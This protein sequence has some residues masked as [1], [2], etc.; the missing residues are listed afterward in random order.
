MYT[1][2]DQLL[3]SS[4]N[5]CR[6]L[7]F[8]KQS[9]VSFHQRNDKRSREKT[10]V[11][12]DNISGVISYER[13]SSGQLYLANDLRH[14]LH[15][16]I[17]TTDVLTYRR[18]NYSILKDTTFLHVPCTHNFVSRDKT[19]CVINANAKY[20]CEDNVYVKDTKKHKVIRKS[21]LLITEMFKNGLASNFTF[22]EKKRASTLHTTPSSNVPSSSYKETRH[23]SS[24]SSI[25]TTS[26]SGSTMST[27]AK[28]N[29][30]KRAKKKLQ[31]SMKKPRSRV[32]HS[33]ILPTISLGWTSTNCHEY[34]K[35]KA[36]TAG[37]IKPFLRDGG[38]SKR[39]KQLLLNCVCNVLESLPVEQC[40]NVD[41]ESNQFVTQMRK[42][43]IGRFQNLLGGSK[44]YNGR[45]RVEGITI[46]VPSAIGFH[47]DTMNCGRKGMKSVVSINVNVPINDET[48]PPKTPLSQWLKDNGCT[49]SFPVSIILYSRKVVYNFAK[50]LS[51]SKAL[52]KEDKLSDLTDWLLTECVGS[53]ID[54]HSTVWG[55]ENF[56]DEFM[57]SAEVKSSSRFNGRM[58]TTTETIDK[59]VSE[60]NTFCYDS[61]HQYIIS[62]YESS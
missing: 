4:T 41:L 1:E 55:N 34:S 59:T 32:C 57:A 30:R 24:I 17:P 44:E 20:T 8:T 31:Q 10:F 15:G 48:V 21:E 12:V 46:T 52:G 28:K 18:K 14:S 26:T 54:Y 39:T 33:D 58:M 60:W 43:M 56:A 13:N 35:N 9:L 53:E 47:R 36:T 2:I 62:H 29:K 49:V 25:A 45:F 61:F 7:S 22:S 40:F 23:V 19:C 42:E 5:T 6:S 16:T 50:K 38:L 37:N 3:L 11:A 27:S 51:D